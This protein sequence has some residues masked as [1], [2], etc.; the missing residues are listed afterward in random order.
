MSNFATD[1]GDW[2][3][4]G[5]PLIA[6][7]RVG[8]SEAFS[9]AYE[10]QVR[11]EGSRSLGWEMYRQEEKLLDEIYQVTGERMD[12]VLSGGFNTAPRDFFNHYDKG[13]PLP[14][15]LAERVS[16]LEELR[17]QYPELR[18]YDTLV[19]GTKQAAQ[20]AE[21]EFGALEERPQTWA[22]FFGGV[23]GGMVGSF[24][25]NSDPY[26][27][28]TL[29]VGGVGRT[30][31]GRIASEGVLGSAVEAVN[32]FTGVRENRSLLGLENGL[33]RSLRNIALAAAGSA[34]FQAVGEGAAAAGRRIFRGVEP[35]AEVRAKELIEENRAFVRENTPYGDTPTAQRVFA[36]EVEETYAD[37]NT[38]EPTP[39]ARTEPALAARAEVDSVLSEPVARQVAEAEPALARALV[40][41]ET[42]IEQTK[43]RIA[44]I[45]EMQIAERAATGTQEQ[46]ADLDAR[47]SDL[48][49]QRAAAT[50]RKQIADLDRQIE[51]A[52]TQRAAVEVPP[53][54]R[55]EL[56]AE[57]RKELKAERAKLVKAEKEKTAL[58]QR[59]RKAA[60]RIAP[61]QA[62]A[63]PSR[64]QA[65]VRPDAE[66]AASVQARM[67]ETE[68]VWPNA[69]ESFQAQRAGPPAEGEAPTLADPDFVEFA[70]RRVPR[71]TRIEFE[72]GSMTID[73]LLNDFAEDDALLEAAMRCK[74]TL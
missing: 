39:T 52:R 42:V 25:P 43:A 14:E 60:E 37:L 17:Q 55:Q 36:D 58:E 27:V 5:A 56:P 34:G 28:M 46:I 38:W 23:A 20:T 65:G 62:T 67:Q 11:A 63:S 26:N 69:V 73:E 1:Y 10:Q 53:A 21:A 2:S 19:A 8:F 51:T 24:N 44:E 47:I 9:K 74:V 70:G 48:Q 35:R 18:N 66:E 22:G 7:P 15:P 72:D 54:D 30:I 31:A 4:D 6:G 45:E 68:E 59:Y 41:N 49:G 50:G 32:E 64:K 33:E 57:T 12:S 3:T 40:Q 16:R 13:A 61:Q 29:G 71:N